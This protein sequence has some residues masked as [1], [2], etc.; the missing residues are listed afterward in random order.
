M[1]HNHTEQ[2]ATTDTNDTPLAVRRRSVLQSLAA[3]SLGTGALGT[4]T[5][6]QDSGQFVSL[7]DGGSLEDSYWHQV[8]GEAEYSTQ[9]N[10]IIGSSVQGSPNSF[11]TYYQVFDDF[12][13]KLEVKL[14]PDGLN[15]GVQVRSNLSQEMSSVHG[16]QVEI[17]LSGDGTQQIPPG[18]AGYVYGEGL[19]LGWLSKDRPLDGAFDNDGWNDFRIRVEGDSLQTW[20]N[21]EPIEED[22][23]LSQFDDDHLVPWGI[24][25]LQVHSINDTGR[26][27]RW[28]N[29][30]IKELDTEEWTPL[31]TGQNTDEWTSSSSEGNV[32]VSDGVL[33]LSGDESFFVRTN[34][35]YDDF[36]FETWIKADTQGG[37]LFR[38]SSED[39]AD[40]YRADIDP[41][42]SNSS[43]SVYD[44]DAGE[45]LKDT[46]GSEYAEMAFKP[47]QWNYYRV[48]AEDDEIRVWVNGI[49]MAT[50]T[51]GAH[52]SG[53]LGFQHLGGDGS[54]QIKDASFKPVENEGGEG[55]T[56]SYVKRTLDDGMNNLID[57]S[58]APDGRVFYITRGADFRSSVGGTAEIGVITPE[59]D[60][61]TIALELDI[62]SGNGLEDGGQGIEVDPNF[63]ENGYV[64]IYY[65]PPNEE[66][67]ENDEELEYL[68]EAGQSGDDVARPPSESLGSP[69]NQLSRFTVSDNTIDPD[70]ESKLLQVPVQR[71]MCCHVGGDIQFGPDGEN[72][73]LTTGDNTYSRASTDNGYAPLDEREDREYFDAQRTSANTADLRGKI[74]RI[75]P[76]DDGS[77]TIPEGNLKQWWENETG[78]SYTDEQILPEIYVMGVRNPYQAG[79]DL[80]TGTLFW[81]DYSADS[82]SWSDTRGP[83]GFNEFNRATR[84]GNY[85]WPLF[86]G[87]FPFYDY[88]YE[89]QS[90]GDLFDA[91]APINDSPHSAGLEQLPPAED[92]LI[93][94]PGSWNQALQGVPDDYDMHSEAP[95]PSIEGGAPIGG[96]LF[97]YQDSF[98]DQGIPQSHDG[99]LFIAEWSQNWIK[100]VSFEGN[101]ADSAIAEIS[102]FA[103]NLQFD[104]PIDLEVGPKGMLY[105]AEYGG[106]Y[107]EANS[108]VS[109]IERRTVELLS[110]PFGYDAGGNEVDGTVSINDVEFVDSS[111]SVEVTGNGLSTYATSD[112]IDGTD[113]DALYQS[114]QVASQD[115]STLSYNIA[116]ENGTY[117]LTLHFA[118]VY[119]KESGSGNGT[120]D[121]AE[122]KRVLNVSIEG[123]TVF[124]GLD[125]YAE[126]GH[127]VALTKT[128]R[129]VE[130]ADNN[131]T[132][133]VTATSGDPKISGFEIQPTEDTNLAL[134]QPVKA[135]SVET[136]TDRVAAKAVDGNMDTRWG[137]KYDAPE[138]IRVDLGLEMSV[139]EV[140]LEWEAAY[141]TEYEIQVS[142]D[143]TNWTTVYTETNGDGNQDVITFE[144]T[145]ARYVRVYGQ[146]RA[147]PQYGFS[148]YEFAVIGSNS[149]DDGQVIEGGTTIELGGETS[150]W[151]GRAPSS[152]EEAKNPTLR[153]QANETYQITWENLDGVLHDIN[154][155][156]AQGNEIVGTETMST[157][158]ETQTLEFTATTEMTA[159]NCSVHPN[160][161]HGEI[162]VEEDDSDGLP[163]VVGDSSPTDPD[164]DG[165]Y[166]DINGDG[167]ANY[168]D[169][170]DL[171]DN[172][173]EDA[174]QDNAE[175]FDFN[176]N[177]RLDF[178]DIVALFNSL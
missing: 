125:I 103:S 64:Y 156:N 153:L 105:V 90:S 37:I 6:E 21:G 18:E 50:L 58:V 136:D 66:V 130:V 178:D 75:T 36:I 2:H 14:D 175:A 13:L 69:Y 109:R 171:F 12:E 138:W 49:T 99:D 24:I 51:N 126:V 65:S 172:M 42:D 147:L 120:L 56:V 29:I 151:K 100:T 57:L 161:M 134:N 107:G 55:G 132:I 60:E 128:I 122:G 5:A 46:S 113:D 62:F 112:S 157:E 89:T 9:N 78:E 124:E 59:A 135:S 149:E 77:Y 19:G 20:I 38:N 118:E 81:G 111:P 117:D 54:I 48:K 91:S 119:W 27:V 70:S 121:N 154:I 52:S 30:Q 16:P 43:G 115:E 106:R 61:T 34:E 92:P 25:G 26:T 148:L 23:D 108:K 68:N 73:Y 31:F 35:T 17:E 79:V 83:P 131:L 116:V 94:Y 40:G 88:D 96:P 45:Y 150:G 7:F 22:L 143:D 72:L 84:A 11:L 87:P 163:P 137:S 102:P 158:G 165:H 4:V 28:R 164:G 86:T 123:E 32:T 39:Q 140:I 159:Y 169:V 44:S 129:N 104:A 97:R 74:L 1:R 155:L 15:S 174:V 114:E 8:E 170:V 41:T 67:A 141:A 177:G 82:G 142:N 95:F 144:P 110:A 85:G 168:A 145:T 98:T 101:V 139:N 127:D 71:D 152:I 173:E 166:E 63:D 176:E 47:D 162:V 133:S 167:E 93:W 80:K 33:E 160:L 3:L 10:T 53:Y 146:T 76:Q